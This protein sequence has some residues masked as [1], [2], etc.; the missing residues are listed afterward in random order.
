M[1]TEK[2]AKALMLTVQEATDLK[3]L[4]FARLPKVRIFIRDV[5]SRGESRGFVYNWFG[6]R[7]HISD[8]QFAYILPNHVIQGGGAD[9]LKIAMNL[10]DAFLLKRKARSRMVLQVHDQLLT[11][12]HRDELELAPEIVRIM[13]SVYKPK[14]KMKLTCS[15]SHS[16]ERWGKKFEK[17]G[18]PE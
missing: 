17:A 6:R 14:N 4:Y 13:E 12:I 8:P 18:Y 2:L 3:R 7:C 10:I 15:A 16:W 9:V 5:V 11:E 1:G